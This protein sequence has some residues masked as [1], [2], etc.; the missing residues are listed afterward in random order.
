MYIIILLNIV[1]VIGRNKIF[2]QKKKKTQVGLPKDVMHNLLVYV[3]EVF[4]RWLGR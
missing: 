4:G 3:K 2:H 1:L